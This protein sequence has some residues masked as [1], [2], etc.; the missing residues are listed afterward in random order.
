MFTT[1][2]CARRAIAYLLASARAEAHQRDGR[3]REPDAVIW[4]T[5]CDESALARRRRSRLALAPGAAAVS[6]PADHSGR[7]ATYVGRSPRFT[8]RRSP[9][10]RPADLPTARERVPS[11]ARPRRL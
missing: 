9:G 11:V 2:R 4:R 1:E 3:D 10:P 5:G 7:G 6:A 8:Q